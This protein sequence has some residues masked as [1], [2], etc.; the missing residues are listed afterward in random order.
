MNY[1]PFNLEQAKAQNGE[2]L[3]T[4]DG[5]PARIVCWDLKNTGKPLVAI[6]VTSQGEEYCMQFTLEGKFYPDRTESGADLFMA[7]T[8]HEGW[9]NVYRGYGVNRYAKIV[10]DTK[11]DADEN[12]SGDRVACVHIEW[13]E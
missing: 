1:K 5:R 7:P 4:R 12:A 13:E 9:I 3:I 8:K 6:L 11:A 10:H 2:G